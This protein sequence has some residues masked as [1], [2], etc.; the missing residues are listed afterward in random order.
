M[1]AWADGNEVF[2]DVYVEAFAE[3]TDDGEPFG[4]VLFVEVADVEVN[5]G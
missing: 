2:A 4:E 3:F 1:S 5:V